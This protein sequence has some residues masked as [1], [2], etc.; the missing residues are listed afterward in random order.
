MHTDDDS[1]WSKVKRKLQPALAAVD[2]LIEARER[3]A[4]RRHVISDLHARQHGTRDT[5]PWSLR[6]SELATAR[7][8]GSLAPHERSA[9]DKAALLG[10]LRASDFFLALDP[11]SASA[12]A[13][14]AR[15]HEFQPDELVFAERA[16]G[17]AFFLVVQ[18]TLAVLVRDDKGDKGG[19]KGGGGEGIVCVAELQPGE[20]FG[21][22]SFLDARARECSVCALDA[23]AVLKVKRADFLSMLKV[24]QSNLIRR[25][26]DFL[27]SVPILA[28]GGADGKAAERKLLQPLAERAVEESVAAGTV[29]VRQGDDAHR[30][31]QR[32]R[33]C[34]GELELRLGLRNEDGARF[35]RK[36]YVTAAILWFLNAR[37]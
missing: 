29:V 34:G 16:V 8:I 23:A 4:G 7:R 21:E 22:A 17:D 30:W 36:K 32:R 37:Y 10:L 14:A 33:R 3:A 28:M 12:M 27:A 35:W 26:L 6:P 20:S 18:G 13:A 24:A 1:L 19:D 31:R 25:N 9:D 15:W 11:T 2:Q 5:Q